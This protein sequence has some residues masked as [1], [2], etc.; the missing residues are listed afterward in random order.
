MRT[1]QIFGLTQ[2]PY[3]SNSGQFEPAKSGTYCDMTLFYE[4]INEFIASPQKMALIL[5][6]SNSFYLLHVLEN[7]TRNEHLAEKT[8]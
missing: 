4:A 3:T 7:G 6:I 8:Y 1:T 5:S 2:D